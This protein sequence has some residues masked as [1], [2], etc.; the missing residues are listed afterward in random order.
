MNG[1]MNRLE[2]ITEN[3]ANNLTPGYRRAF[4]TDKAFDEVLKDASG[5]GSSAAIDFTSAPLK[6]TGNPLD[7][8]ISGEGFFTVGKDNKEYYTRNGHFVVDSKG[9][10][11]TDTGLNVIGTDG[12]PVKFQ[13]DMDVSALSI[14]PKGNL[15]VG[16]QSMAQMKMVTFPDAKLLQRVGTTLFSRPANVKPNPPKEL[17]VSN[18]SLEGSNTVVFEEMANM[19][20]CMRNY[21]SCTKILKAQDM[22]EGQTISQLSS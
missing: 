3:L 20:T 22:K 13:N 14:D 21:E 15:M 2:T 18:R 10:L 4:P 19:M 11:K 16:G 12:K 17:S 5:K 7:F 1:N 8:A 9:M 6:E